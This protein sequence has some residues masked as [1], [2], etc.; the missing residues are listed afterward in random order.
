[1]MDYD[2][3]IISYPFFS[4]LSFQLQK[5]FSFAGRSAEGLDGP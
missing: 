1:M 3:R 2:V 4:C 5:T